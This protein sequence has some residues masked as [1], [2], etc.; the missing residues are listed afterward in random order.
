MSGGVNAVSSSNPL[1]LLPPLP[2][3]TTAVAVAVESVVAMEVVAI[4]VCDERRSV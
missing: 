2:E 1:A 3:L 4:D